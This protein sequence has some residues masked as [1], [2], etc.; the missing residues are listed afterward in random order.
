MLGYLILARR[1]IRLTLYP[2]VAVR[3]ESAR[4]VRRH[5]TLQRRFRRSCLTAANRLRASRSAGRSRKTCFTAAAPRSGAPAVPGDRTHFPEPEE[6]EPL[7][8]EGARQAGLLLKN[9]FRTELCR[10]VARR[11]MIEK[12]NNRK[13]RKRRDA[14]S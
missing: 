9:A 1:R 3:T 14:F 5:R 6:L 10:R 11:A 4:F 12:L 2:A 7:L 13:C 8:T